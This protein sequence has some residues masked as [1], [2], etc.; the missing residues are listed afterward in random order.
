VPVVGKK[1]PFVR[2][3]FFGRAQ[4]IHR[5]NFQTGSKILDEICSQ[6][7]LNPVNSKKSCV[8]HNQFSNITISLKKHKVGDGML[9]STIPI[10]GRQDMQV[11]D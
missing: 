2:A 8:I 11:K 4:T 1:I 9:S 6:H 3:F 5:Q 10:V 7:V